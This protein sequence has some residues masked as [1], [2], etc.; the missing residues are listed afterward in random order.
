MKGASLDMVQTALQPGRLLGSHRPEMGFNIADIVINV[1]ASL[2]RVVDK[3]TSQASYKKFPP[4]S[5]LEIVRFGLGSQVESDRF[6]R[7]KVE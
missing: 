1:A 7:N 5:A 6:G 4:S 2:K 3:I